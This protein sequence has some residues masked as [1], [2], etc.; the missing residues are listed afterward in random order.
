ME[1]H[2][3]THTQSEFTSP[4]EKGPHPKN[5]GG[6]LLLAVLADVTVATVD[7]DAEVGGLHPVLREEPLQDACGPFL[8]TL[9]G[10]M[11]MGRTF[12]V[13]RIQSRLANKIGGKSQR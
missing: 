8:F 4:N 9:S 2:T 6:H 3:H 12:G 13:I 1:S 10:A 5:E 11:Q 7:L